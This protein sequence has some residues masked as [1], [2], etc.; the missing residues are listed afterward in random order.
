MSSPVLPPREAGFTPAE[1]AG[2]LGDATLASPS[3]LTIR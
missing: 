1:C 2:G 3:L